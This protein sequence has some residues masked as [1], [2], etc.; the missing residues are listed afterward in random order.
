[1]SEK[2]LVVHDRQYF[3]KYGVCFIVAGV[4][5]T[6]ITREYIWYSRKMVPF[7]KYTE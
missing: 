2:K 7:F 6:D 4:V 3:M 1:M 5:L